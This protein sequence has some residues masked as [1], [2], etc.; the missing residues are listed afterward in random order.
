[1]KDEH[2]YRRYFRV[3]V[4]IAFSSLSHLSDL[5]VGTATGWIGRSNFGRTVS[6]NPNDNSPCWD[7]PTPKL[8]FTFSIYPDR[9]AQC[10]K[11]RIYWNADEVQG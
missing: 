1:M 5:Q 11:T 9:L 7:S 3:I 10:E 8:P 6:Q 4:V 2:R